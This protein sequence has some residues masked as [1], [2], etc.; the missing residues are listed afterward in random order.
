[1]H[2]K[3]TICFSLHWEH[4]LDQ[5]I[6]KQNSS[7]DLTLKGRFQKHVGEKIALSF[8]LC[9]QKAD[10]LHSHPSSMLVPTDRRLSYQVVWL[11]LFL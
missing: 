4:I 9:N 3:L 11:L 7:Y 5:F 10:C 6:G 2:G 8:P 1:M